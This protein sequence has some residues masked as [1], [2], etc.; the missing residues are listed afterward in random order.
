MH[1]LIIAGLFLMIFACLWVLF[2][3]ESEP[4]DHKKEFKYNDYQG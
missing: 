2:H 1:D 3:I 4:V